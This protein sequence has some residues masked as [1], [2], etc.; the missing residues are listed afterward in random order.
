MLLEADAMAGPVHEVLAETRFVDDPA[1]STVDTTAELA[2]LSRDHPGG[3]RLGN[4][5]V[6]FRQLPRGFA[7]ENGPRDIRAIALQ[8]PAEIAYDGFPGLDDT[9]AG[10]V[11]R[12]R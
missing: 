11:V 2:D 4:D 5:P 7:G 8:R 10:L 1:R 3:L 6:D 9:L 12:A